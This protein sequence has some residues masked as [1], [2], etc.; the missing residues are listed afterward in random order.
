[1]ELC[2]QCGAELDDDGL[3][4]MCLLGGAMQT[5]PTMSPTE[6]MPAGAQ[7]ALEYDNFGN[8]QD[9]HV[10]IVIEKPAVLAEYAQLEGETAAVGETARKGARRG[11]RRL[12]SE[13]ERLGERTLPDARATSA[14]P[15]GPVSLFRRRRRAASIRRRSCWSA[16]VANS[17]EWH[18]SLCSRGSQKRQPRKRTKKTATQPIAGRRH[19]V[20]QI[21]CQSIGSLSAID[22]GGPQA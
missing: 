12:Q 1:M 5:N 3:C 21:G 2:T 11:C 6:G 20:G 15:R 4:G 10:S 16:A 7:N 19:L 18:R 9:R 22:P 14:T 13:Q 8:Y 17:A